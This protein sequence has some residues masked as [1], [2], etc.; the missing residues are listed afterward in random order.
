MAALR[1][2]A[3]VV[4]IAVAAS[5]GFALSLAPGGGARRIARSAQRAFCLLACK[6]LG[7][8]VDAKGRL[9]TGAPVLLVANHISWTD[10]LALG[11]LA[12]LAFVARHDLADWPVLGLLAR[13][14]GALFVERGRRRQIPEINRQMAARLGQS[15]IVALFPEAT[16]GDGTRVRKFHSPHFAAAGALLNMREEV[17]SVLVAPAAISYTHRRGLPLGR[18]GRASVA[19]YGDTEFGPHLVDLLQA[20]RTQ[21][22]IRLLEPISFERNTSRKIVTR[23]AAEA[24]R[25]AF[26]QEIMAAGPE[27]A[28]AYVLSSRQVV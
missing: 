2:F 6:A 18:N 7:I 17:A 23:Q 4:L 25:A 1:L 20:G 9:P 24:I 16:T 27:Q 15:E 21:C 5:V 26:R 28:T 19:W 3:I 11:S 10:I 13:S 8:I 12:P 14:Y 22:T